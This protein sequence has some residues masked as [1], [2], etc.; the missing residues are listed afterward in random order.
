MTPRLLTGWGRTAPSAAA[1][2]ETVGGA[3]DVG[4]VL[5]EAAAAGRGALAR[6]LEDG[7]TATPPRSPEA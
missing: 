4:R 7:P 1:D 6:G 5:A 3:E 2:V